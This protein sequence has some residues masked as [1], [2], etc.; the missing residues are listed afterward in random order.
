MWTLQ[1]KV[2]LKTLKRKSE[3]PLKKLILLLVTVSLFVALYASNAFCSIINDLEA[4]RDAGNAVTVV[5]EQDWETLYAAVKYIWR[6]S[7]N[8][9]IAEQYG[10]AWIDYAVE[11]KA[12]YSFTSLTGIGIFFEPLTPFQTKVHYVISGYIAY[13]QGILDATMKEL[14]Y[15]LEY[16]QKNYR[17]YTKNLLSMPEVKREVEK[18]FKTSSPLE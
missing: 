12:I 6:H 3:A 2:G 8:R 5:Y 17:E 18:D 9:F 1:T 15:L 14:P 10:R 7:E 13:F 11:E 16:G 4:K